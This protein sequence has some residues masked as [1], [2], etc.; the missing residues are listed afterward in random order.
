MALFGGDK[1]SKEEKAEMKTSE[2]MAR[3]GLEGLKDP[4]DRESV[5]KIATELM[6]TGLMETGM[7]LSMTAKPEDQLT[8]QYLR[9]MME[10]NWII[11]RQLDALLNK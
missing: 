10:Q 9:T 4:A 8:V 7:K 11:I 5:R 3:Y 6:G 1:M 2:L